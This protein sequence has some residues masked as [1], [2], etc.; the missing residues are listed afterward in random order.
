MSVHG[1]GCHEGE[2]RWGG[3][4]TRSDLYRDS[5]VPGSASVLWLCSIAVTR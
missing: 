4:E 2:M 5:S 3:D 1:G